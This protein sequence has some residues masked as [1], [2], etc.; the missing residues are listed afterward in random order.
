M[1]YE[2]NLFLQAEGCWKVESD[3]QQHWIFSFPYFH[4]EFVFA[5]LT[6]RVLQ[7]VQQETAYLLLKYLIVILMSRILT[8]IN[9]KLNKKSNRMYKN[10]FNTKMKYNTERFKGIKV[11]MYLEIE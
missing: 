2:G 1:H 10:I 3:P 11:K 8:I 4:T 7:K 9:Y 6:Q 5:G